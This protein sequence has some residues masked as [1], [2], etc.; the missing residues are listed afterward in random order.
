VLRLFL[1]L[2]LFLLNIYACK[3]GYDSCKLKINDSH[4][5]KNKT[6][7]APISHHKRLIYSKDIPNARI[8]KHDPYLS[9]Y[10][11]EDKEKFKYPFRFNNKLA[12]GLA[13]VDDKNAIEGCIKKHQIGLNHFATLSEK[14]Y[15]PALLLTSCCTLKGFVT[16]DGIIEQ[17]YLEHFIKSKGVSYSDIGIRVVDEG[18][19]VLV[20]AINPFLDA[21]YFRVG[22]CIVSFDGKKV[23][24]S[25]KLMQW[26]LFSKIGASHSVKIKRGK[27]MLTLKMKSSKRNGGGYL[28]D[29]F[30]EFLGLSFDKD[31]KII[32]IEEKAKAY[33][34][35]LGDKL[36]QINGNSIKKESQVLEI[37]SK[38]KK[39]ANLLFERHH[40]QFF[41]KI[42]SI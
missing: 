18:K 40:F 10:L 21:N 32:K 35:R 29:T 5:I 15:A 14:T 34:L 31:L 37:I 36:V 6:I 13:S 8:I 7:S 41:V 24:T 33:Q 28:S 16:P 4:T 39:S 27:D 1:T 30:L 12:S 38:S 11:V 22:D 42:K 25:A 26:I 9:L 3:G 19:L 23:K 17:V 20:S 2:G